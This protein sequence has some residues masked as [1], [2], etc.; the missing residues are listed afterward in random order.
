[1]E[2]FQHPL[3]GYFFI[4]H[5][6]LGRVRDKASNPQNTYFQD[7]INSMLKSVEAI[8]SPP[9]DSPSWLAGVEKNTQPYGYGT[10]LEVES[11]RLSQRVTCNPDGFAYEVQV[12]DN[13]TV[14]IFFGTII[15]EANV[16][17]CKAQ[18][19]P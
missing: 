13:G 14:N 10:D 5:I 11:G 17:S 1:L 12:N 3:N 9:P 2:Y 16:E 4:D 8:L 19:P 7:Q 15:N 18:F 6:D